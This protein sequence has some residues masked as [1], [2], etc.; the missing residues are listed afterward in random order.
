MDRDELFARPL[1]GMHICQ[2][3]YK[4]KALLYPQHK[5]LRSRTRHHVGDL[6]LWRHIN[7]CSDGL[8]I[9]TRGRQLMYRHTIAA[10]ICAQGNQLINT[11]THYRILKGIPAFELGI[12]Q[13][14][15]V[16]LQIGRAS[17]RERVK[18]AV[19]EEAGREK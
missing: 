4:A 7:K 5:T 3:R 12:T 9:P 10:S 11:A 6:C 16:S 8:P 18:I 15:F 2:R 19:G 14:K 13:I 17:C 1:P